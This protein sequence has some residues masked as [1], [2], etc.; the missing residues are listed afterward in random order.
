MDVDGEEGGDEYEARGADDVEAEYDE[1]EEESGDGEDAMDF[2]DGA[3]VRKRPR[4]EMAAPPT[5]SNAVDLSAGTTFPSKQ[6]LL[7]ALATHFPRGSPH[8]MLERQ[9]YTTAADEAHP[10]AFSCTEKIMGGGRGTSYG[11]RFTV[12]ASE[13]KDGRWSVPS[14]MTGAQTH[15]RRLVRNSSAVHSD[16][17]ISLGR[18]TVVKE[19]TTNTVTSADSFQNPVQAKAPSSVKATPVKRPT[20]KPA[21][22]K[23]TAS[24]SLSVGTTFSSRDDAI[25]AADSV[26][27]GDDTHRRWL[28]TSDQGRRIRIRCSAGRENVK[29]QFQILITRQ[30]DE[31]DGW[32]VQITR[33][34]LT[35]AGSSATRRRSTRG[36][37]PPRASTRRRPSNCRRRHARSSR[38]R[39]CCSRRRSPSRF[40]RRCA[41]G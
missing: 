40:L 26:F 18:W 33:A 10:R 7:R 37:A 21:P 16:Q 32:C 29:C 12:I 38:R 4:R 14:R 11:C 19:P 39:R 31:D 36:P 22:A 15:S 20:V 17:S 30:E 34:A 23:T 27:D 3:S 8:A 35:I 25:A 24:S 41:T 1:S 28:D 2:D 13:L 5:L 9:R 6:A